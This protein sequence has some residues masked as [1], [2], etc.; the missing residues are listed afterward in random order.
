MC[1]R[2]RYM[3]IQEILYI[4][5]K[6]T[7]KPKMQDANVVDTLITASEF[8]DEKQ[9][10]LYLNRKCDI[11]NLHEKVVTVG[12]GAM[13]DFQ[14]LPPDFTIPPNHRIVVIPPEL[15]PTNLERFNVGQVIFCLSLKYASLG[16]APRLLETMEP[17]FYC[18]R[19]IPLTLAL[20]GTAELKEE[21][22]EDSAA[23]Q[24][25]MQRIFEKIRNHITKTLDIP[26]QE[27][28]D[29]DE[30]KAN[31]PNTILAACEKVQPSS[32]SVMAGEDYES[33][34]KAIMSALKTAYSYEKVIKEKDH[35]S[36]KQIES[37]V[38]EVKRLGVKNEQLRKILRLIV[39]LKKT[40]PSMESRECVFLIHRLQAHLGYLSRFWLKK[41]RVNKKPDPTY[42]ITMKLVFAAFIVYL[43]ILL[44]LQYQELSALSS[45]NQRVQEPS[46]IK[47]RI[48]CDFIRSVI[49]FKYINV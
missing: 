30:I 23:Y 7:L 3:G 46:A 34:H 2:D 39:E 12:P 16:E 28:W 11:S 24:S 19:T 29:V 25:T 26:L 37:V 44:V 40:Q 4:D 45:S 1:I 33:I 42:E 31:L 8:S 27:I 22:K 15:I 49:Y 18:E 20:L 9:F 32:P 14:L 5:L 10:V 35:F 38:G 17:L 41:V 6:R 43:L 21:M 47:K 13:T 36:T 48:L